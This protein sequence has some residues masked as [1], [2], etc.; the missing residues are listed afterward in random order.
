MVKGSDSTKKEHP[1][2][3]GMRENVCKKGTQKNTPMRRR[4]NPSRRRTQRRR[5]NLSRRGGSK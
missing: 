5:E 1:I 2:Q 3:D 4:E